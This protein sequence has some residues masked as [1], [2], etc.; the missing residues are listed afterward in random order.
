MNA[1][2][3]TH[4][5]EKKGAGS[6]TPKMDDD[7]LIA[8]LDGLEDD[9]RGYVHG[10][11]ARA[12]ATA[13][14]EYYQIPYAEDDLD[15]GLSKFITSETQNSI[16]WVL[17]SLLKMFTS[18]ENAVEFEPRKAEDEEGASQATEACNYA[19][20]RQNPG[21]LLLLTA[22]K[23]ALMLRNGA[24]TWQ[25][26]SKE[27]KEEQK[28]EAISGDELVYTIDQLKKD[29]AEVELT[30]GEVVSEEVRDPMDPTGQTVVEPARYSVKLDVV[31]K[32][33]RVRLDAVPPE[34][35]LV[36]RNWNSP[37]LAECPYV[38]LPERYTLSEIR[39]MGYDD[40]T[41]GDLGKDDESSEDSDYRDE[42]SG[43]D[44]TKHERAD[45]AMQSGILRREWVLVDFDGDGIAERR[46][47]VRLKNKVL[48]NEPC[49]HVPVACGVP[50]LRQHRWDGL[51][52]ADVVADIQGLSTTV[53]RSVLNSLYFS[54]TPRNAVLT[55][56]MGVPH[57]N[58]D[59]LLN[60]TPGSNVREKQSG[61]VRPLTVPFVG[62]QAMPILELIGK[63]GQDRTGI[64]QYFQGNSTDALNKTASGTAQLTA[65][66]QQRVELIARMLAETLVV[67]TF[68]GI[69]KLLIEHQIEPLSFRLNNKFVRF[70]PQEWRD[71]YDM[72]INVGLGTGNK[73]QVLGHL[74]RILASQYQ[75]MQAGIQGTQGPLVTP[76]NL[77]ETHRKMALNCG[78]P[79]PESFFTDPGDMKP[80]Q[81]APPPPE[82]QKAQMQI[83]ADG[84]IKQMTLGADMQKLQM[85]QDFEA[86][87]LMQEQQHAKE[88]E[89]LK[90]E[91][92]DALS[93]RQAQNQEQ[94]SVRMLEHKT[95][96]DR[97]GKEQDGQP[98]RSELMMEQLAQLVATA[99]K[100]KKIRIERDSS[101]RA[102]GASPVEPEEES[103]NG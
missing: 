46:Y 96:L 70:D 102:V 21:F 16:E 22:F 78:F 13:T 68:Q 94:S 20:Y 95:G 85:E 30:A 83:Q 77:Y 27:L 39:E 54:V 91:L 24:L 50:I 11:L 60:F 9:S 42:I 90:A 57:A 64:N 33:G 37:L 26:E 98:S 3:P 44:G 56:A 19:F 72:T 36:Y 14:A 25:W 74:T 73:D 99:S 103:T 58:V 84:Q 40:V 17:P 59:D 82:I 6:G 93:S 66:T 41:A 29:G 76:K 12:R 61:A 69:F 52:L 62:G 67:P 43:D 79:S 80:P 34:K 38:C 35:V 23:D 47:V 81:P 18:G 87:R 86:R 31:R 49:N 48:E 32:Q 101:G 8:V 63:M 65:A 5:D 10:S 97:M 15:D 71:Q 4:P 92:A 100:P 2:L 1:H 53:T 51:S 28:F 55:D 7:A 45:E 75:A 88:M 89:V